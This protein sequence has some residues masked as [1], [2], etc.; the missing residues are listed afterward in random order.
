MFSAS[1][2]VGELNCG[3]SSFVW[4]QVD[5]GAMQKIVPHRY[6]E[7][8]DIHHPAVGIAG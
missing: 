3:S 7:P 5:Q 6:I 8:V 1:R 2:I 4:V